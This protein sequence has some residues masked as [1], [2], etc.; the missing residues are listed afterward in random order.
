MAREGSPSGRRSYMS[1]SNGSEYGVRGLRHIG[2]DV[3]PDAMCGSLGPHHHGPAY[4]ICYIRRGSVNW[5]VE[6]EQVTVEPGQLYMTRPHEV[7]GAQRGVMDRCE[8]YWVTVHLDRHRGSLG[9]SVRET[10][11]LDDGLAKAMTRV[12]PAPSGIA[13]HYEAILAAVE[14]GDELSPARMRAHLLLLLESVVGAYTQTCAGD[15]T[16]RIADACRWLR[17][18]ASDPSCQITTVAARAGLAPSR[19]R[20]LFRSETG[21]TPQEFLTQERM[22]L[23][24][25][26]L[27]ARKCS[28][29]EIALSCGFNSSQYFATAFKRATGETPRQWRAA[30]T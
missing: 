22:K 12:A 28:I 21:F 14:S 6:D 11:A 20:Y 17:D 29:T 10:R 25:A 1:K 27:R 7:H 8:L 13:D 9:L 5:W 4:E 23:A 24:K 15:A 26:M 18:N 16:P 2:W 19:F 30:T 3:F